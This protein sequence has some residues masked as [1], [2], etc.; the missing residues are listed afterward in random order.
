MLPISTFWR[1]E[2]RHRC[3]WVP[4]RI[5]RR[6]CSPGRRGPLASTSCSRSL[7]LRSSARCVLLSMV[8]TNSSSTPR[9]SMYQTRLPPCCGGFLS[10]VYRSERR[11]VSIFFHGCPCWQMIAVG[12]V[13]ISSWYVGS[14]R[15]NNERRHRMVGQ[16]EEATNIDQLRSAVRGSACL[17]CH[18]IPRMACS[19]RLRGG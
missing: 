2:I 15:K 7:Q 8:T 3:G 9:P 14:V 12:V 11:R 16:A 1:S 4:L 18:G 10:A 6:R 17:H 19:Q 13:R 5:G